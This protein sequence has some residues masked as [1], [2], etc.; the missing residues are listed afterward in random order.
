MR[1][2]AVYEICKNVTVL[3]NIFRVFWLLSNR[4]GRSGKNR[5]LV[6]EG[7]SCFFL[8][9]EIIDINHGYVVY[10]SETVKALCALPFFFSVILTPSR[11]G[12][13][14][15]KVNHSSYFSINVNNFS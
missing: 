3:L 2:I 11:R 15:H 12:D 1:Y 4:N 9:Q 7:Y 14:K 8:C 6:S 5:S 13:V 10:Y